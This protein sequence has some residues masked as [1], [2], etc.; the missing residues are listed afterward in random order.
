MLRWKNIA[1]RAGG[2]RLEVVKLGKGFFNVV[3][4]TASSRRP[5]SQGIAS[6]RS[7]GL[8]LDLDNT[9]FFIGRE[10][11]VP[12]EHPAL[13]KWRT[14]LYIRLARRPSRRPSSI[15]CRPTGWWSWEPRSR[16]E[17]PARGCPAQERDEIAV[18]LR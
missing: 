2:P 17:P 3:I 13:G 11:L 12:S 7:F 9:T 5:T 6:A 15:V 10:T 8:A 14:W 4:H 16:S 18:N 1:D